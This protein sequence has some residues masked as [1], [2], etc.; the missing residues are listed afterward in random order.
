MTIHSGDMEID[1]DRWLL[2]AESSPE[3]SQV[4]PALLSCSNNQPPVR[5]AKIMSCIIYSLNTGL[6]VTLLT[7]TLLSAPGSL[8]L[9]QLSIQAGSKINHKDHFNLMASD[10]MMRYDSEITANQITIQA[11]SIHQEGEAML[12]VSGRG[13][14]EGTGDGGTVLERE[15][16]VGIGAGHGGYGGGADLVDLNSGLYTSTQTCLCNMQGFLTAIRM[17]ILR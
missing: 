13:G 2:I 11:G 7:Y 17:I 15:I 3:G 4:L 10:I 12:D 1:I 14:T 9:G 16:E 6:S 8:G 5:K